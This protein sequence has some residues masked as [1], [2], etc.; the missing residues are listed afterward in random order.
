VIIPTLALISREVPL[1]VIVLLPGVVPEFAPPPA[2]LPPLRLPPPPPQPS[3]P[4]ETRRAM[5]P[6][7]PNQ[8]RRLGTA[9]NTNDA[10][11]APPAEGHRS[12]FN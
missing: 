8:L 5:T 1:T 11:A 2:A 6:N 12:F 4:M 3:V 10:K 9:K 7:I